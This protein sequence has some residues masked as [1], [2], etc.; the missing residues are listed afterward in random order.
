MYA[1]LNIEFDEYGGESQV[2]EE[3]MEQAAKEMAERGI[4][5]ED[6]GA[7]LIDFAKHVPGKEGKQLEKAVIRK[8]DGTALYLTRDISELM[9]RHAK[10]NFD[11]MLYVI[12]SEQDLHMKQLLKITEL[13]GHQDVATKCKHIN[14]GL[15]RGMSTRRGTVQFL[16][17]I[18]NDVGQVMHE[19][20]RK[21]E[22]KYHQVQDPETTADTL[23]ISAVICQDMTGK[24]SAAT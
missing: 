2:P 14:F 7:I 20:M 22:A 21:N 15:V 18:L 5:C 9:L 3:A 4:S 13:L 24:R 1:R 16:D 17:D 12:A 6:K 10:Y 8:R 23:G 11:L 19:T